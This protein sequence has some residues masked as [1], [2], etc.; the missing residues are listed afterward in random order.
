MRYYNFDRIRALS[1]KIQAAVDPEGIPALSCEV[2]ITNELGMPEAI[3]E[4]KPHS[5]T[6][7]NRAEALIKAVVKELESFL[8][9]GDVPSSMKKGQVTFE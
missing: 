4:Y 5:D 2:R 6:V 8:K 1:L 9:E 3:V 7:E